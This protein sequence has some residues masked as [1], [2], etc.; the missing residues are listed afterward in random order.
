[1]RGL[2]R[3]MERADREGLLKWTRDDDD[4]ADRADRVTAVDERP[5]ARPLDARSEP[6]GTSVVSETPVATVPVTPVMPVGIEIDEEETKS[7]INSVLVAATQPDSFAAEQYRFLR[8]R[9][10]GRDRDL[11]SQILLV[12][13]PRGGDGKTTTCANLALTMARDVQQKVVLVEADVRRPTLAAL[14]GV[15][16]GPGLVDVLMGASTLEDTLVDVPGCQLFLL[17]AGH[18]G[19]PA[20]ELFASSMMQRVLSSL[21]ARFTR[22]LVD[23]PPAMASDT[24]ALARLADR[25]LVVVR[26]GVTPRPALA[27]TLAIIDRQRLTGIVLNDVDATPD[28]Y[29][30][31][32]PKP[33]GSGA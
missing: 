29:G 11:R 8:T 14:L 22:I 10:E 12:T 26:S 20:S 17:P 33:N 13:S 28:E 18:A 7:Q 30:Y 21:R 9:L 5:D 31:P 2:Q 15:G 24:Q 19:M 27:R 16:E 32:R 1:M 6:A 23:T 3:A 25:V 4:R